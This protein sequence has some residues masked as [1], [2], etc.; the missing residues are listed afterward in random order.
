MGLDKTKTLEDFRNIPDGVEQL[1]REREIRN[2]NAGFEQGRRIL[3]TAACALSAFLIVFLYL[4]S[5]YS[6]VRA[7]SIGGNQ[8]LSNKYIETLAGVSSD[9]RYFLTLPF[10]LEQKIE[11]DPMIES[12]EV[13]MTEGNAIRI[14]V[15]EKRPLGYRYEED[16][17]Y[18]LFDDDTK[19]ELTSDYMSVITRVPYITGFTEENQTHLLTNALKEISQTVIEEIAEVHQYA[20]KYDDEAIEFMMRDGTIVFSGYFYT[21]PLNEYHQMYSRMDNHDYCMYTVESGRADERM[22]VSARE[23]PWD[24]VPI[25]HEYWMDEEGDYILNKYG[26]RIVK[27]YYQDAN[28]FY[29]LDEEGNYILIPIN[30]KAEDERDPDFEENYYK[31]YYATGVLVTPE[32]EVPEDGSEEGTE[33]GEQTDGT[34]DQPGEQTDETGEENSENTENGEEAGSQ[35]G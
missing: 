16:I 21:K 15:K 20:L 17:P 11:E 14:E 35:E 30:D 32:P 33:N 8:Y 4:V 27:H 18:L 25:E 13:K 31:G 3:F 26:D 19:A 34:G 2:D 29:F 9:S 12:A 7:I 28:G 22:M 6:K 10:R 5:P 1:F 24:E 23:C